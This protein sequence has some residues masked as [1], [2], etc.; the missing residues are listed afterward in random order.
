MVYKL[1]KIIKGEEADWYGFLEDGAI[2][3]NIQKI[4]EDEGCEDKFIKEFSLTYTHELLHELIEDVCFDLRCL[5]EEGMIRK[6]LGEEWDEEIQSH[7]L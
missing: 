4:W 3:V 1:T 2:H 5:Y 6:I 7:Y